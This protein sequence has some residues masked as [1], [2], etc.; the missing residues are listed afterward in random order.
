MGCSVDEF[1][2]FPTP[3]QTGCIFRCVI[4]NN[5]TEVIMKNVW[6]KN[7][8]SDELTGAIPA[9]LNN[10]IKSGSF[11]GLNQLYVSLPH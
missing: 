11:N 7:L 9:T 4:L 6:S 8:H 10:I 2:L 5:N 3:A 1:E